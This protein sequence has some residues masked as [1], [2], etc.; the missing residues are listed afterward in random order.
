MVESW[1]IM[2]SAARS[3]PRGALGPIDI[4][5]DEVGKLTEGVCD[6]EARHLVRHPPL[7]LG[8]LR[9]LYRHVPEEEAGDIPPARN[10]LEAIVARDA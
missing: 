10:L 7:A 6:V 2:F 4:P 3:A 8:P 1:D 9:L 5:T